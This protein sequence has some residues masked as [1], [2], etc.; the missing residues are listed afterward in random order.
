MKTELFDFELPEDR[1][2]LHPARERD[3]ARLLV[4]RPDGHPALANHTVR[5][6]ADL[7]RPGDALVLNDTRVIPAALDGTR[8]RGDNSARIALN[9]IKRLGPDRWRAFARPAKRLE[10][11]DRLHFGHDATCVLWAPSTRPWPPGSMPARSRSYSTSP[12]PTSTWRS[13]ASA[14]CRCRPTSP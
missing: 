9:L 2:A 5:D 13:P 3:G 4:V 1:I 7:L 12:A 6:L 10:P 11:G 14:R 8:K